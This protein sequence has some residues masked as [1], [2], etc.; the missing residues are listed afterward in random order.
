MNKIEEI[1]I[2]KLGEVIF[3]YRDGKPFISG[4]D[5][6]EACK[7]IATKLNELIRALNPRSDD[8]TI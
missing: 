6:Y 7:T 5:P 1:N 4:V 3:E 8:I 2:E